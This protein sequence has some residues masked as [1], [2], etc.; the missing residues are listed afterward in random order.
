MP[1]IT[2]IS[3]LAFPAINS[4]AISP[5]AQQ[6]SLHLLEQNICFGWIMFKPF[7]QHRQDLFLVKLAVDSDPLEFVPLRAL[8]TIFQG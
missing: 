2:L 5:A 3:P 7:P 8:W 6:S 1:P 4:F